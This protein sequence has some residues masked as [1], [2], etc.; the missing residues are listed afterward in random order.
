MD[1]QIIRTLHPP[2]V[3]LKQLADLALRLGRASNVTELKRR[4]EELPR[5]DRLLLA[6]EGDQLLG[7]AHLR[8]AHEFLLDQSAEIIA[9]V[10]HPDHRRR[11][12]GR[13]LVSAAESW[14]RQSGRARL[15]MRID[16]TETPAHGFYAALGYEQSKTLLEFERPLNR[17]AV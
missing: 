9:I 5:E 7:Y 11:G 8:V 2:E 14:A 12:I 10:V 6:I 15:V 17:H 16:V 1:L 13:R 3:Y 4:V